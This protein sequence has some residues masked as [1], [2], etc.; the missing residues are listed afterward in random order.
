MT[1]QEQAAIEGDTCPDCG[2]MNEA[3]GPDGCEV[4]MG[5]FRPCGCQAMTFEP[6][7]EEELRNERMREAHYE[8]STNQ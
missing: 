2:H 7:T 6:A 5:D 8:R 4:R 3:H 1:P